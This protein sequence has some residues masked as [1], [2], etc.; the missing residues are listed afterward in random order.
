MNTRTENQH[1]L[2]QKP[3]NRSEKKVKTAT[4]KSLIL[5]NVELTAS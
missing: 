5:A 3:K 2:T 4:P 1:F